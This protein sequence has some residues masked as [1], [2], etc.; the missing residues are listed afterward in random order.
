M[1]EPHFIN[2]SAW[3]RA[4]VLGAND[5]ILST[6]S[7][8]IGV[9]AAGATREPVVLASAAALVAGALS[10]AAGEYVSVSSQSDL[11]A[12]DLERERVEL[13]T[14][15]EAELLE[16]A[17]AYEGRGLRPDTALE[18]ARQLTAHDA[19]AAHA[20]EE[21][22]ISSFTEANPMQAALAS[23]V[24]FFAGGALPM[25]TSLFLP[26]EWMVGGH[27]GIA[28][29]ALVLLGYASARIGGTSVWRPISRIT[30]WGTAAMG[31]TALVG[32]LLGVS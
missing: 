7:V 25:L 18:V 14:M 20:W 16:L 1:S 24:A 4:A 11:E 32:W 19:L 2:R 8:A 9:A 13:A 6:A 28:L 5:G 27:Y 29:L 26:M 31:I 12:G 30:F 22:G 10:M 17:A 15:P 23:G 3:L 21:L